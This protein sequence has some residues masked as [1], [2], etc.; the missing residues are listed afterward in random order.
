MAWDDAIDPQSIQEPATLGEL[1]K[2]MLKG[3]RALFA[4]PVLKGKAAGTGTTAIAHGQRTGIP[5]FATVTARTA[6]AVG[7]SSID[8]TY[9]YVEAASAC[10]VDILLEML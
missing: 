4:R 5:R 9:V 6:V 3:F 1:H 8:A 10:T 2:R 7:C